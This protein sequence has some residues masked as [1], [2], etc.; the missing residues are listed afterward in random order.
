[1]RAGLE[2]EMAFNRHQSIELD[3]TEAMRE[4]L[5]A[6]G[7]PTAHFN[8]GLMLAPF[9]YT[10]GHRKGALHPTAVLKQTEGSHHEWWDGFEMAIHLFSSDRGDGDVIE[11][12]AVPNIVYYTDTDALYRRPFAVHDVSTEQSVVTRAL[13]PDIGGD[14]Y[15][16]AVEANLDPFTT[17]DT[18]W[19]GSPATDIDTPSRRRS[20]TRERERNWFLAGFRGS[21]GPKSSRPSVTCATVDPTA[22]G[23]AKKPWSEG[24]RTTICSA[25]WPGSEC[26]AIHRSS[27]FVFAAR[28]SS[29][30]NR[31]DRESL[32]QPGGFRVGVGMVRFFTRSL[33]GLGCGRRACS[34]HRDRIPAAVAGSGIVGWYGRGHLPRASRRIRKPCL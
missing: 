7:N 10:A 27:S 21:R 13:A 15:V 1:M 24:R 31:H 3:I 2:S 18:W 12:G 8:N 4:W 16:L 14:A 20:T 33:R 30:E 22:S 34:D 28:R 23:A 26:P 9:R 6:K 25:A 32:D 11:P 17:C 29:E 19:L 5:A